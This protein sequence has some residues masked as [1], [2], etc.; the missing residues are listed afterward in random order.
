MILRICRRPASAWLSA[1]SRIARSMPAILI[2]IWMAVMPLTVPATLKSMSPRK[3]SRPWI[4][5][6]TATLPVSASLIR[7][8][9]TP[10]TGRLMGTPASMRLSVL[11]QTE[12]MELEPLEE[13]ISL[14]RRSA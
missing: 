11:P 2:S 1:F 14:T 13:R 7:P 9:A 3:S 12:A 10:A 6:S 4:S 5:V 8:M